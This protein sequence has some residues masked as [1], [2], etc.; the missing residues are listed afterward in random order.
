[1]DINPMKAPG[2]DGYTAQFYQKF[3]G[4]VKDELIYYCLN[5]LNCGL[6]V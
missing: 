3:W 6:S 4:E 5:V 1:M 2:L